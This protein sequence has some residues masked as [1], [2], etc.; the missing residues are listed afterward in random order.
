PTMLTPSD[1]GE[2][3]SWLTR[4]EQAA[5]TTRP[6][7]AAA[8]PSRS[9]A[10]PSGMQSG[11]CTTPGWCSALSL[12]A[13]NRS[14]S[15]DSPIPHPV[16][17]YSSVCSVDGFGVTATGTPALEMGAIHAATAGSTGGAS[18]AGAPGVAGPPGATGGAGGAAAPAAPAC[19]GGAGGAHPAAAG[20]APPGAPA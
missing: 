18:H 6:A 11:P 20:A 7:S 8:S 2:N 16:Q 14:A 4:S 17:T 10:T 1:A 12:T 3:T 13:A 15:R 9:A 5:M 19:P